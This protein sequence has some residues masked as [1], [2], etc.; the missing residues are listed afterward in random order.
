MPRRQR[1]RGLVNGDAIAEVDGSG[2]QRRIKRRI[3][4]ENQ[5]NL[6]SIGAAKI[7]N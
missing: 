6:G 1:I 2:V 3:Q 7:L 4:D 5:T